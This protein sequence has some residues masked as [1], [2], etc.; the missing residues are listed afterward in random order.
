MTTMYLMR[1]AQTLSN[2][3]GIIQ[4]HSDSH[5]TSHGEKQVIAQA[6]NL[7]HIHFDAIFS[8]DLLRARRTAE[9]IA[10]E[11]KI[12]VKTT[13]IIRERHYGVYEN[14]HIDE[15]MKKFQPVLAQFKKITYDKLKHLSIDPTVETIDHAVSRLITFMREVAVGCPDKT[16]LI[17]SHGTLIRYFL[18]HIGYGTL[19]TL[20]IHSITNTGYAIIETN[21]TEFAVN[22]IHGINKLPD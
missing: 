14:R 3:T 13:Q 4:G 2:T 8:S 19:D 6:K 22:A 18:I 7:K 1:H 16:V 12:A 5:L 17:V 20:P 15:Y 10:L 21:G 9:I 11:K